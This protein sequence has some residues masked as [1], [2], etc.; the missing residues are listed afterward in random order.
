[1]VIKWIIVLLI[2]FLFSYSPSLVFAQVIPM[3]SITP[4][5]VPK[6]TEIEYPLPYPGILPNEPLFILKNLRDKL[7]EVFTLN[8]FKKTEFYLLQADKNLS[9]SIILFDLKEE[10]MALKTFVKSQGYLEKA[11]GEEEIARNSPGNLMELSE[12]IKQSSKK[13]KE[14]ANAFYENSKDEIRAEFK[15]VLGKA[16]YLEK[17][18]DEFRL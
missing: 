15:K 4:S 10:D 17:S 1:M 5:P 16:I 14:L 8:S 9:S 7:L 12:K 13:Q 3:G 18:A 6:T 2:V 11:I